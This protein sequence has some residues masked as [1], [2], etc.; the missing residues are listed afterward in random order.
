MR[1]SLE[2]GAGAIG[3]GALAYLAVEG[4]KHLGSVHGANTITVGCAAAPGFRLVGGR[5]R[6]VRSG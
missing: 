1:V 5:C 6:R 4:G 2:G 3:R